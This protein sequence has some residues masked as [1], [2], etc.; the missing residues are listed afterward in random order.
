MRRFE[1]F[2]GK[3]VPLMRANIDTDQIIPKQF[4]KRVGRTGFQDALFFDWR[5]E[6]EAGRS[7]FSFDDP[8]FAGASILLTGENFGCGSS[9]EHAVWALVDSGIRL[10]I[11]ASLADIFRAN[12]LKNGLLVIEVGREVA[13]RLAARSAEA[14][15]LHLEVD[16]DSQTISTGEAPPIR[17]KI[18]PFAKRCLL[19]GLDEIAL[20][21][22]SEVA[23]ARHEL[24]TGRDWRSAPQEAPD[25]QG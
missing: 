8:A 3:V 10:V 4:L 12:A 5:R 25:A 9:R 20:T 2:R 17:F 1:R 23:I 11:A 18:D 21:L 13:E 16:L 24:E 6:G 15:G 7:R 22:E 14:G 19:E